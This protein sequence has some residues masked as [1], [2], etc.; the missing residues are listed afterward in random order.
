MDRSHIANYLAQA[1]ELKAWVSGL[2][3][4]QLNAH[5]VPGTWSVQQCVFHTLDSDL[6]AGDRMRRIVA[7]DNPLLMGYD[8]SRF[9]ALLC[10]DKRDVSKACELFA[11]HRRFMGELLACLPSD[12]FAR[13]GIHSERGKISLGALVQDYVE[14]VLHHRKFVMEKRAALG[15]P[16][17]KG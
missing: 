16:M 17:T 10:Y 1:D 2:T 15:K 13:T 9:A 12:A 4:D 3:R 7:M 11:M 6:V 14:H 5:P 8:E